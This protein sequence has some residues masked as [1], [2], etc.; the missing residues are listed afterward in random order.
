MTLHATY[1]HACPRCA[2]YYIPYA[3]GVACPRCGLVEDEKTDF[4]D[5]AVASCRHNISAEGSYVPGSW[6]V[7]SFGDHV[8]WV[9]FHVLDAHREHPTAT[10]E[11]SAQLVLGSMEWGEQEYLMDHILHIAIAIHSALE[12]ERPI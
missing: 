2:A 10:F 9:V 5:C 6:Q 11:E 7:P 4:L 1:E 3:L 8:L 12:L